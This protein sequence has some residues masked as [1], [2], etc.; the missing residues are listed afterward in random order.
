VGYQPGASFSST[1]AH[2]QSMRLSFA[3]Y[4]THKI[5]QGINLLGTT[6]KGLIE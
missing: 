6:L 2:A 5:E 3:A 1:G 4:D